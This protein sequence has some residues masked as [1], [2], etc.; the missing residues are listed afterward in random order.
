MREWHPEVTI[1][2]ELAALLIHDRFPDLRI[3]SL[4]RLAAGWD[5]T[6]MLV[7]GELVFR[8]PHR[9]VAIP[10]LERELTVLP[11]LPQLPLAIPRPTHVA[12]GADGD[13]PWPFY[14]TPLVPGREIAELDLN[15]AA[16][17]RLGGQLGEFLR[18]LHRPELLANL[19]A[20]LDVDPN[21][22]AEMGARVPA[23]VERLGQ[24]QAAGL[25][26]APPSVR[27][28]L[29]EA[30][31]LPPTAPTALVHGDLH[32]RHL[33]VAPDGRA[34][35]IIDWGDACRA[36]PALDLP[37]YWSLFSPSG[38]AAF[39]A[40]YGPIRPDQLI[41]ARVLALMLC[42][43]LAVYALEQG[44]QGLERES[45]AGLRRTVLD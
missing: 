35:G 14:G 9:R 24:A 43:A 33:L 26:T 25:W 12:R 45:V 10:S 23:T 38:R 18:T 1:S 17:T 42:A 13:Y 4:R 37:L 7:N 31:E 3:R 5:N 40:A 16:R 20:G 22:R 29:E 34:S 32:H 36:D 2:E 27:L 44:M 30:R 6:V 21:R 19:A 11:R 28:L 15:D 8:F 41:R 39:R